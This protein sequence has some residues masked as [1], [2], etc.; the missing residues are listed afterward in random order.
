M[1]LILASKS[2]QRQDI[3]NQIGLKYE[4]LTS[5]VEETSSQTDP[6]EYVKELSKNKANSVAS[7]LHEKALI[8]AADTIIYMD[9]KIYEKPKDKQEAYQNIKEM[10]GKLTFAITG[11][12]VKD[13]YQNKELC[14]ADITEVQLKPI[15]EEEIQWYIENEHNI[16]NICGYTML[17]KAALFLDKIKGDYNTLFG[18]SPSKLYDAFK[19]LGYTLSDFEMQDTM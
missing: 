16:Q 14:L 18:I 10:S 6:Q 19:K 1:K 3:L 8:V 5:Q 11:T 9:G 12:T 15:T 2:K 17:G 13:M 7:Q 4:I